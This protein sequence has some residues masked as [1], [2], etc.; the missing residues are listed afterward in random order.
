MKPPKFGVEDNPTRVYYSL[1]IRDPKTGMQ[2]EVPVNHSLWKE[3]F[4]RIK[5]K[6]ALDNTKP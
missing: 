1:W 4:A 5:E 2:V 3:H 6:D